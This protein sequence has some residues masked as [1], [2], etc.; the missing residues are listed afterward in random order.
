MHGSQQHDR[1]H[2]APGLKPYQAGLDYYSI[3]YQH[4]PFEFTVSRHDAT[5]FDTSG[6]RLIL[7]VRLKRTGWA[8]RHLVVLAAL[9]AQLQV[10]RPG[11]SL[12]GGADMAG[13]ACCAG[14]PS[15]P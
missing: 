6:Q 15:H 14:S 10:T 4:D 13:R 9:D 1:L 8:D 3:S 7:K 2:V 12:R 11:C 5:I